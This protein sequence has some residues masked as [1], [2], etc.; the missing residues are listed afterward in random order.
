MDDSTVSLANTLSFL[1]GDVG[2]P[3]SILR[4]AGTSG[5]AWD[6][7]GEPVEVTPAETGIEPGLVSI[8]SNA[9]RLQ[10]AIDQLSLHDLLDVDADNDLVRIHAGTRAMYQQSMSETHRWMLQAIFLVCHAFP[11]DAYLEPK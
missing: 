4:R 8:L 10:I 2:I 6:T 7:N 5:R 11:S 3:L 9:E 1:H